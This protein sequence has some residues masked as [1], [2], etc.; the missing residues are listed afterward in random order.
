MRTKLQ[1]QADHNDGLQAYQAGAGGSLLRNNIDCRPVNGTG[2]NST[3][4]AAIFIAD[5]SEGTAVIRDNYLA[6]GNGVLRLH[7]NMFY[8]VTGNIIENNSWSSGTGPV[9]TSN[10]RAGAFLE[11][12]N[13]TL[14]TGAVLTP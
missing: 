9:S 5:A 12:S 13:N 1:S 4:T 7:E 2:D 3:T 6:G 10:S 8:R 11:W 14:T